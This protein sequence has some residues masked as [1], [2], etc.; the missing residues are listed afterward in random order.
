MKEKQYEV[1]VY[2][3]HSHGKW[4]KMHYF[5]WVLSSDTIANAESFALDILAGM[6]P[7]EIAKEADGKNLGIEYWH[8]FE[9]QENGTLRYVKVDPNKPLG[10]EGAESHF[11]VKARVFKG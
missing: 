10:Y 9:R 2:E 11:T 3:K 5:G 1:E 7:L 8:T 6:T 4:G